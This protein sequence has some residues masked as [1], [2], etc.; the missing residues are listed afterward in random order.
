[1][2]RNLSSL[3]SDEGCPSLLIIE[4]EVVTA[5]LIGEMLHELG[6]GVSGFA[7]NPSSIQDELGKHNFDAVL[8]DLTFD[9]QRG[10]EIADLLIEL[11]L[12]FAFVSWHGLPFEPRH[13]K[14]PTLHKPLRADRLREVLH[15]LLGHRNEWRHSGRVIG[16]PDVAATIKRHFAQKSPSQR[17]RSAE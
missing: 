17:V 15:S 5:M 13:S 8:L 3:P 11:K 4:D 2:A 9:G 10:P 14:V 12:P 1:M 16:R 7:N 6:Y